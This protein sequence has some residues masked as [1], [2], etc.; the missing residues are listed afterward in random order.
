MRLDSPG[1]PRNEQRF[2]T[3]GRGEDVS[4]LL[5]TK[6]ICVFTLNVDTLT[7]KPKKLAKDARKKHNDI[8]SSRNLMVRY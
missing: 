5:R 2:L 4:K 3:Q 1:P 6:K 8:R 7:G